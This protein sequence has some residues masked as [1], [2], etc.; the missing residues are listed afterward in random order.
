MAVSPELRLKR[1]LYYTN[2]ANI[3]YPGCRYFHKRYTRENIPSLDAL[4]ADNKE[5][6]I[7][8]LIQTVHKENLSCYPDAL[9]FVLSELARDKKLRSKAL[10]LAETLC[11]K[12]DCFITFIKFSLENSP[13]IGFGRAFRKFIRNW[14]LNK[15]YLRLAEIVGEMK[16]Y[17]GWRH[18]DLMKLAHIKCSEPAKAACFKYAICGADE[19]MKEY[20]ENEEA[21]KVVSYL[22]TVETYRKKEDAAEVAAKVDSYML[23][24]E[25]VNFLVLQDKKVWLALLRQM[26]V[27]QVLSNFQYMSKRKMFRNSRNW[28]FIFVDTVVE[29]LTKP[30]ADRSGVSA[31]RVFIELMNYENAGRV[32]LELATKIHQM[33]KKPPILNPELSNAFIQLMEICLEGLKPVGKKFMVAIE[34]SQEM[35]KRRCSV[36]RYITLIEAAGFIAY[37]LIHKETSVKVFTFNGSGLKQLSIAKE[38]SV[39]QV[40][41]TL[42]SENIPEGGPKNKGDEHIIN[43]LKEHKTGSDEAEVCIVL[44]SYMDNSSLHGLTSGGNINKKTRF[45]VSDLCGIPKNSKPPE[46]KNLFITSGFDDKLAEAITLF[47]SESF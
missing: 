30:Y 39:K 16:R 44:R 36:S 41:E 28:D 11:E 29:A 40:I 8:D 19:M 4:L 12:A 1:Y 26:P 38:A 25:H 47:A 42:K 13:K 18:C 22:S 21:K 45:I 9:I 34:L 31:N 14:Y 35:L 24:I 6:F 43:W 37:Y 20:G 32:K 3:Y 46:K 23:G 17:K 15:D 27:L 2:E 5:E 10:K 33:S 7:F